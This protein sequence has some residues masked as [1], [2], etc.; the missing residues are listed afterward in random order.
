MLSKWSRIMGFFAWKFLNCFSEGL[1][2]YA[3]LNIFL[4]FKNMRTIVS[5]NLGCYLTPFLTMSYIL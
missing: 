5:G 2:I 3:D 4:S 1:H